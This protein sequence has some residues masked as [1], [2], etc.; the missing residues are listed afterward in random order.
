[1]GNSTKLAE[2]GLAL[3]VEDYP[4]GSLLEAGQSTFN[5]LCILGIAPW[6]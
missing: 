4:F 6:G 5:K 2:G 3:A 1:M